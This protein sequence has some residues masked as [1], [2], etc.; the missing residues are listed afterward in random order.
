MAN[1]TSEKPECAVH[2]MVRPGAMCSKVIVGMQFCGYSGHCDHQRWPG[3]FTN[4][5]GDEPWPIK[6]A[7]AELQEMREHGNA[8]DATEAAAHLE[9]VK[10]ATP[11]P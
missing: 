5:K 7:E 9:R 1:E 11:T 4:C 10:A 6:Q 3:S 8:D 2:G